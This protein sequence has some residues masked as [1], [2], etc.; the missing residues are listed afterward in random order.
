[1]KALFKSWASSKENMSE[2]PMLCNI[3]ARQ[4]A[5]N[6]EEWIRKG[7]LVTR[8][9]QTAN[10]MTTFEENGWG[11]A[12]ELRPEWQKVSHAESWVKNFQV[13]RTASAKDS[14]KD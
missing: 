11:R 12:E 8:T 4:E 14:E 2:V 7:A 5:G 6:K 1:M 10:S 3:D 9:M 13:E